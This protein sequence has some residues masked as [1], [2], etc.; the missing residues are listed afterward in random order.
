MGAWVKWARAPRFLP[1]DPHR[2]HLARQFSEQLGRKAPPFLVG[3]AEA[4]RSRGLVERL[5]SVRAVHDR[6][7][8]S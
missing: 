5:G 6:E 3:A 2:T 4:S 8:G 1:F 7:D